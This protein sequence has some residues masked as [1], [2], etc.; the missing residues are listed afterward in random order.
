MHQA[1]KVSTS[2]IIPSI[3]HTKFL[4]YTVHYLSKVYPSLNHQAWASSATSAEIVTNSV[5]HSLVESIRDGI[6]HTDKLRTALQHLKREAA[7][8]GTQLYETI[9]DSREPQQHICYRICVEEKRALNLPVARLV[10]CAE[11]GGL[12]WLR[13]G[14]VAC[15]GA[16]NSFEMEF[17]C[18]AEIL[19]GL[20]HSAFVCGEVGCPCCGKDVSRFGFLGVVVA[21]W[22]RLV[23]RIV[24]VLR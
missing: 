6:G 2:I 23:S 8:S 13:G 1:L 21:C 22:K 14:D 15:V 4:P 18:L 17:C 7:S 10:H 12:C 9:D 19:F 5:A 11:I 3:S 20:R 16:V 24:V